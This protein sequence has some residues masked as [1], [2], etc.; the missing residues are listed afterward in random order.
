[1]T[2]DELERLPAPPCCHTC[3][4][5]QTW[6]YNGEGHRQACLLGKPQHDT[7]PWHA[8]RNVTLTEKAPHAKP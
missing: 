4:H 5:W 7:C 2:P 1:M 3:A 8:V 6:N